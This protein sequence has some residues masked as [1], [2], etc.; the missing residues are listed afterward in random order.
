MLEPVA[1]AAR[2]ICQMFGVLRLRHEVIQRHVY[3]CL[4]ADQN[5]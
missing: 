5:Q 1:H 3:S 2:K 4:S